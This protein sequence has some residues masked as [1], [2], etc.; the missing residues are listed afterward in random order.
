MIPI[1]IG[2]VR[3]VTQYDEVC[4]DLDRSFQRGGQ[5]PLTLVRLVGLL[6]ARPAS[7][8]AKEEVIPNLSYL[9]HRS[10]D[11]VHFYCGGYWEGSVPPD[12]ETG[13]I[14]V[15]NGWM[16][17]DEVFNNVRKEV[18]SRT[19]WHYSGGVDLILT[20]ARYRPRRGSWSELLFTD[21]RPR[22]YLDFSSSIVVNLE[23][24]KQ[25]DSLPSVATLFEGICRYA[26]RTNHQDPAWSLSDRLG[27][28]LAVEALKEIVLCALPEAVRDKAKVAFQYPVRDISRDAAKRQASKGWRTLWTRLTGSA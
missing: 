2:R 21:D 13:R 9:H 14:Q 15:A 10:A 18:E 4:S 25:T 12:A 24:L 6:F 3:P 28:A 19:S 7:P 23:Q 22:S 27:G 26:E 8:L 16:Y 17:S 11:F 20:N 5:E 1:M